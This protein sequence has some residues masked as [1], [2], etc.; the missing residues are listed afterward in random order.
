VSVWKNETLAEKWKLLLNIRGEVTKALEEARSLKLI[1]HPLDAAVTL[2]VD[3]D[4]HEALKP[5]AADL[6][7][8]LIVSQAHLTQTPL[9]D[10][11]YQSEE[12][13]GLSIDVAPSPGEKCERCWTHSP[14]VGSN[15]DFFTI[16]DRCVDIMGQLDPS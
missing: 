10:K 3:A 16:C 15:Q 4:T 7:F 2:S 11:A 5:Y 9:G 1:G 13:A 8:I 12:I 6:R 14:S